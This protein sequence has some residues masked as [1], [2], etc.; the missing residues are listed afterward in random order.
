M[1][2]EGGGLAVLRPRVR[3]GAGPDLRTPYRQ[4]R[5]LRPGRADFV[6]PCSP[7]VPVPGR[8]WL[9]PRETAVNPPVRAGRRLRRGGGRAGG[10]VLI[11]D[12]PVG[13]VVVVGGG[14]TSLADF[15]SS[16]RTESAP[17][18]VVVDAEEERPA[19]EGVIFLA[20]FAVVLADVAGGPPAGCDGG[21][22]G[23][24]WPAK[25]GSAAVHRVQISVVRLPC[26][27]HPIPDGARERVRVLLVSRAFPGPC[28]DS[29]TG[30]VPRRRRA[31]GGPAPGRWACPCPSRTRPGEHAA[32]AG[33]RESVSPSCRVTAE[34]VAHHLGVTRSVAPPTP[35]HRMPTCASRASM[36]GRDFRTFISAYQAVD[37]GAGVRRPQAQ[38]PGAGPADKETSF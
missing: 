4:G 7:S 19:L 26:R 9:C 1:Q 16:R 18:L 3:L 29:S 34:G 27:A 2:S 14:V 8:H 11:R 35:F 6:L 30:R 12:P 38:S 37:K 20:S 25:A 32:P 22:G 23:G 36:D 15:S 28:P 10:S 21:L 31:C 5:V 33:H 24:A 17:V 13:G